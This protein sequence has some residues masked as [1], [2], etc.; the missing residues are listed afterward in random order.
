VIDVEA[1]AWRKIWQRKQP[2]G[3]RLHQ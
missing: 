3:Q 1:S 2:V